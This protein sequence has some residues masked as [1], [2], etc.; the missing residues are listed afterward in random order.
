MKC[1]QS[2]SVGVGVFA[3]S[4]VGLGRWA[5]GA[6]EKGGAVGLVGEGFSWKGGGGG[7]VFFGGGGALRLGMGWCGVVCG[8]V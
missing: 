1:R 7:G 4:V 2:A 5:W 8:A 3:G 6:R